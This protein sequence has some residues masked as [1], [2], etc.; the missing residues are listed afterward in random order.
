MT[1]F[2]IPGMIQLLLRPTL[3][4]D[5]LSVSLIRQSAEPKLSVTVGCTA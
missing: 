5:E 4:Y 3:A 2:T 1:T